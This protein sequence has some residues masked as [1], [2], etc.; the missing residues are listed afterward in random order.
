ML[1]N[2]CKQARAACKVLFRTYYRLKKEGSFDSPGLELGAL[3][4]SSSAVPHRG[5]T[6]KYVPQFCYKKS[7]F[8]PVT[9]FV[10]SKWQSVRFIFNTAWIWLPD[11]YII[12]HL[13]VCSV[14]PRLSWTIYNQSL[15]LG[16]FLDSSRTF[17]SRE[18]RCVAISSPP[19]HQAWDL[20]V[21]S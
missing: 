4:I 16:S 17:V 19:L 11:F 12:L 8:L 20:I 6:Q 18:S 9:L 1:Y 3:L 5:E 14:N 21:R 7:V 10:T 2:P 15:L 13:R